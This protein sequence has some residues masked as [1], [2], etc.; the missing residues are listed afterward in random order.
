MQDKVIAVTGGASGIALSLC[1]L[2]SSRGAIVCIAD[3]TPDSLESTDKYFAAL[4]VPYM[5]TKVDVTKRDQVDAWIESIMAKYGRLDGAAN[6]AGI[7]GKHHGIRAVT[8]LDDDEWDRIMNVNLKGLMFCL[9]AQLKVI[10]DGGSIVNIASILG[11]IGKSHL[12]KLSS[13]KC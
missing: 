2:I 12:C 11:R 9:R 13:M 10:S 8:E 5:I 4:G 1:K 7:V 6:C 3:V